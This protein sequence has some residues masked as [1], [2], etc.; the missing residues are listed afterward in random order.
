MQESIAWLAPNMNSPP[1]KGKGQGKGKQSQPKTESKCLGERKAPNQ[2]PLSERAT[3][4]TEQVKFPKC[5]AYKWTSRHVCHSC[6]CA[7]PLGNYAMSSIPIWHIFN[8]TRRGN[9]KWSL[10]RMQIKIQVSILSLQGRGSN[11]VMGSAG[12]GEASSMSCQAR[13]KARRSLTNHAH[14][15]PNSRMSCFILHP[16]W[17][18]V[19][20]LGTSISVKFHLTSPEF[21]T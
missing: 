9:R 8:G 14:P 11:G 6:G 5:P 18:I 21:F 1:R 13:R 4:T 20:T 17:C 19:P 10:I 3:P 16:L 15:K 2:T 7:P 12:K